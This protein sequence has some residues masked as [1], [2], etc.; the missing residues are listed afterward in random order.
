MK[1]YKLVLLGLGCYL[2]FLLLLTPAAVW[3]RWLPLPAGVQLG[4]VEGSLLNGRISQLE[5]APLILQNVRWQVSLS[6][7]WRAELG[8][9]LDAGSLRETQL[10]YVHADARWH[11]AG[12]QLDQALLRLPL[13]ALMQNIQLPMQV[14][15][16]GTLV[17]DVASFAAGSP[18]CAALQGKASWQQ[19]RFKSPVG[20]LDL[21]QIDGTL[22][23]EQGNLQLVTSANNP[24]GLAVTAQ[25]LAGQYQLNGTLKP[26]ASMPAAVHDA[27]RFVGPQDAQG[28]Y[29]IKLAGNI[30]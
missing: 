22:S 13:A 20:W 9:Q 28:R 24:L 8:L 23:C 12:L 17:L 10:P 3:F 25:L 7:L 5:R 18:Y 19:A 6:R 27:M 11:P 14:D 26:A 30:R 4:Q 2:L 1:K 29:V 21:Q 15:A 16:A